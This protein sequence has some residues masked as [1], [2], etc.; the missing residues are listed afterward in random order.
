MNEL[1]DGDDDFLAKTR[2]IMRSVVIP[3]SPKILLQLNEELRKTQV[4]LSPIAEII[5]KDVGLTARVLK[6]ANSPL[7]AS[8]MPIDSIG[9]GLTRMGIRNFRN[10]VM[11]GCLRQVLGDQVGV[12]DKFWS[13]SETVAMLCQKIAQQACPVLYDSAYIVGLFHDCGIPLMMTRFPGYG[14][15]LMSALSYDSRGVELE[16][17]HFGTHHG[18]AGAL[19]AR[20]WSMPVETCKVIREHHWTDLTLHLAPES[21]SM[22]AVLHLA[23]RIELTLVESGTEIFSDQESSRQ[24]AIASALNMKVESMRELANDLQD[25]LKVEDN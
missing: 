25:S 1:P 7:F 3:S 21:M 4:D 8:R 20:T 5:S 23:E 10:A 24:Q 19:L 22:L 16:E 14:S 17:Q 12:L 13:H 18:S 9:Q 6:I 15:Y 2:E 11:A